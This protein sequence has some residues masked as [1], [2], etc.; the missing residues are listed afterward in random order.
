[1]LITAGTGGIGG[2]TSIALASLGSGLVD[3]PVGA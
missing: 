1:M 2:A 3:V